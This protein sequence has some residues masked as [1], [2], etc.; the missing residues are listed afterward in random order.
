[1][2]DQ[3]LSNPAKEITGKLGS[4]LKQPE[5]KGAPKLNAPQQPQPAPDPVT[6]IHNVLLAEG[7]KS[8]GK[9]SN[10]LV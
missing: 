9:I 8:T 1:M 4:V 2:S 10:F 3:N 7:F 6:D 5:H